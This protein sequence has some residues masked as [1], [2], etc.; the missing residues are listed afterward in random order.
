MMR[1]QKKKHNPMRNTIKSDLPK[2]L[3]TANRT[4]EFRIV[5][6]LFSWNI[7]SRNT[8]KE[9]K[10]NDLSFLNILGDRDVIC[11]QETK[12]P[13]YLE[14]YRSF[15]NNRSDST[16]GGVAILVEN[17]LSKGVSAIKKQ[18]Y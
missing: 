2:N 6:K 17:E 9:S 5:L 7:E 1:K 8:N 15:N 3:T 4:G 13:V 11:L 16:S 10:F 18:L 14:N 12:G